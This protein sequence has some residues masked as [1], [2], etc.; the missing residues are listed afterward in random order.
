MSKTLTC[1]CGKRFT[2]SA[3]EGQTVLCPHCNSSIRVPRRDPKRAGAMKVEA[4]GRP[5]S[6]SGTKRSVKKP[7]SWLRLLVWLLPVLAC[8]VLIGLILTVPG[9]RR[10]QV[11]LPA[12]APAEPQ[13]AVVQPQP[14]AEQA[15]LEVPEPPE[16]SL[17]PSEPG[18]EVLPPLAAQTPGRR[19]PKQLLVG[20]RAGMFASVE[21]AVAVAI[22]G[23][24]IE[25]R[26]NQPMLVGG[27]VLRVKDKV[28]D[29]PLTIRAGKGYQPILRGAAAAC[30][31]SGVQCG[32]DHGGDSLCYQCP[33][34]LFT[35]PRIWAENSNVTLNSCS[36]TAIPGTK[37]VYSYPASDNPKG[38]DN[39]LRVSLSHCYVRGYQH[40][41][42]GMRDSIDLCFLRRV[43]HNRGKRN[44][45]RFYR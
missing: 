40:G 29:A 39:Q 10:R 43:G 14:A 7:R 21:D 31:L 35:I 37:S 4:P 8:V 19:I 30:F 27:A 1:S 25:I 17:E 28:Q 6:Q 11:V 34:H 45:V 20:R 5:S 15:D 13:P 44:W 12:P 33:V 38:I 41:C 9:L 18:F 22:P 36:F 16:P 2:S 42:G 26:T 3:D 24:I 23:D 32:P